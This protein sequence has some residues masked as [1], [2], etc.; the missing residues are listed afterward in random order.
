[1]N[2]RL[3]LIINVIILSSLLAFSHGL[4][5]WV[6]KKEVNNYLDLISSYWLQIGFSLFIYGIVFFYY[7]QVLRKEDIAIL[8]SSYTGLSILLVL[9]IG[10]SFFGESLSFG[11]IGGCILIIVGIVLIGIT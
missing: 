8:Y 11:Q 6:A 2:T 3:S 7:I 4:L 5:K 10:V 1:M 9:S